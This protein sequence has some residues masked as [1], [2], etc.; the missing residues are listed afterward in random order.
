MTDTRNNILRVIEENVDGCGSDAVMYVMFSEPVTEDIEENFQNMLRNIKR[1]HIN[2]DYCTE[3]FVSDAVE[4]FNT[5]M[6]TTG[7]CINAEIISAP[8]YGV[9]TF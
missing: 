1:N 4:N 3:D 9:V 8:Y 5:C 2:S 7:R 6:L